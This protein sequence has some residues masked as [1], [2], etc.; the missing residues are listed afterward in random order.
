MELHYKAVRS[1]WQDFLKKKD[2]IH[3]K[4][5][6]CRLFRYFLHLGGESVVSILGRLKKGLEFFRGSKRR[7]Y[8]NMEVKI[9][10]ERASLVAL[11]VFPPTNPPPQNP[12][13]SRGTSGYL[14]VDFLPDT[15]LGDTELDRNQ[16]FE[17]QRR[18]KAFLAMRSPSKEL[19]DKLERRR[20]WNI[21]SRP[22]EA[23]LDLFAAF[24]FSNSSAMPCNK[25]Q[26]DLV[27]SSS[28]KARFAGVAHSHNMRLDP[29]DAPRVAYRRRREIQRALQWGYD[30]G[31]IPVMMTLTI[32]HDWTWQPLTKLIAVLR[33]SYDDLFE[34]NAGEKL[35]KAIGFQYRIFRMEETLDMK[36]P[37]AVS[38]NCSENAKIKGVPDAND[39]CSRLGPL[40]VNSDKSVNCDKHDG[41]HGWHP[42]YHIVL[43]VP[44]ENLNILSDLEPKLKKRWQKLV[45]KHYA[46]F[47]G[48]EIPE[49]YLPALYKHGLY[50]SR[51][52]KDVKDKYGNVIHKK[53]ELYQVNDSKYLAKIMG[54]D[55]AEMYGGDKE[56]AAT[57]QKD[58]LSPFDLLRGEP[59]AEKI[60]L[61]N[62]YAAATKGL[63]CFR[64]ARGFKEVIDDYF[65]K[66]PHRDPVSK[67]L[68]RESFVV[69]IREEV[70]HL[71]YRNFKIE[72]IRNIITNLIKTAGFDISKVY[73]LLYSWLKKL[74]VGWGFDEPT[75]EDLFVMPRAPT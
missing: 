61:W 51:Y 35:R 8:F 57:L 50:L 54:C 27:I 26:I 18:G 42:H 33:N 67:N 34:H 63:S 46:K 9:W 65:A 24:K 37:L 59:T 38:P 39:N 29:V 30:N 20:D 7:S 2:G 12:T 22:I 73:D 13:F 60:D 58:S 69:S 40:P 31:F 53:G 44:K 17:L 36:N 43:F 4:Q 21:A 52:S 49:S 5:G 25:G 72:E 66:N 68:P 3:Q 11:N 1:I 74:F 28:G 56:L 71:L 70:Y 16:S 41:C 19:I 75:E 14:D 15:I 10:D 32:F 47:V 55:S 62:E 48:E 64:F 23:N 45:Q 6:E